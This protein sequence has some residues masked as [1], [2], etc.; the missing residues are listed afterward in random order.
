MLK[1]DFDP[2]LANA[3]AYAAILPSGQ[4]AVAIINKDARYDLDISQSSFVLHTLVT[5]PSLDSRSVVWTEPVVRRR[6]DSVPRSSA[7]LLIS[8]HDD[9]R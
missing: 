6:V 7:A 5:A 2:G 8:A 1:L 4:K 3:T 9:G